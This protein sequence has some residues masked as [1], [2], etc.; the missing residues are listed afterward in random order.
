M[1]IGKMTL[2]DLEELPVYEVLAKFGDY[3]KKNEQHGYLRNV[4]SACFEPSDTINTTALKNFNFNNADNVRK[5]I[6]EFEVKYKEKK[7]PCGWVTGV[8][9]FVAALE[10][11]DYTKIAKMCNINIEIAENELPQTVIGSNVVA[12]DAGQM[13]YS[14]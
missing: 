5:T 4:V 1:K 8:L 2:N 10:K 14:R 13:A 9:D 7:Q 12:V 11:K 6:K 3:I